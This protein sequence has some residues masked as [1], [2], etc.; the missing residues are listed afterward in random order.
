MGIYLN[1]SNDKFKEALNSAIY[2]DKS[3]LIQYTN[4]V[5]HTTQ[6]YLCVSRPRRFGK[7]IT[8]DMLVSYYS[9]GCDSKEIFSDLCIS[10]NSNFTK[11]M[12]KYDTIFLNMQEFLSQSTDIEGMIS[13]IQRSVLWELLEEY[14]SYRYFDKKNLTR[15]M[16]DIYQNSQCPFVI[17]IDE[18]DCIFREYKEERKE[19]EHYLDFLRDLLKDKSHIHLV[20]MTGILPIKKYGTHSALNMFDEYSMINPRQL[21]KYTGF[22][23]KEV[24]DLCPK[25]NMAQEEMKE[26]YDGYHFESTDNIYNPRSVVAAMTAGRYDTYWNQ[27]ETFEALR[28]YIDM[29]FEELR[30][31]VLSMMAGEQISV[32]A[33]S[34]SNDMTTFQ[35]K[36]D[37]LTLLVHLGYLGYNS[38]EGT[39]YIPNN[40]IRMEY[41]NAVSVSEWGEV[42]KSL[43]NSANTLRAIWEKR[44][45]PVVRGIEQAHFET[46]H[47]QYNDEN[48]L[49]YTIAL[50]L[51]GARNYYTVYRE[52]PGG[53]GFADMVYVPKR[54][55]QDKPAIVVE[56]KWDKTAVGAIEQIKKRRYCESLKEYKGN[57]LLVGIN[58]EKN[59]KKHTCVIEEYIF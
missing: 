34:F 13:L 14:P 20:Y 36:D 3:E 56:L 26:W 53:K 41:A 47:L 46:S 33:K 12:N 15:T 43:K 24:S 58:Y 52:L 17:V 28:M 37:V 4:K 45:E 42:S 40:E 35:S 21:A 16:K 39:V 27:T 31:D 30:D 2:V 19:Q 7:S 22:T 11:Y 55:F 18:W 5:L 32:N 49:S 10:K 54:K 29:N 9:R 44:S 1:P 59:T 57:I 23:E 38:V 25:Y 51:Y 8:A 6:K 48:A 50:A